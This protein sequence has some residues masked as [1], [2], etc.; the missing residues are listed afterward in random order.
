[1]NT[2]PQ[3]P[4]TPEEEMK[5]KRSLTILYLAM[6]VLAAAPFVVLWWMNRGK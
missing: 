6:G 3:R 2:D 5:V 4:L 1:M